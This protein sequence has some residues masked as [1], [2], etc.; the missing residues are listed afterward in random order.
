MNVPHPTSILKIINIVISG[1]QDKIFNYFT[2]CVVTAF[3][4]DDAVREGSIEIVST[5]P[6]SA[7]N[8]ILGMTYHS[9]NVSSIIN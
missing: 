6:K 1:Y 9:N 5:D 8:V 3:I 2:R 7:E 4:L